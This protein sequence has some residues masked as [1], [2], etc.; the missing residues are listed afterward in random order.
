[1]KSKPEI[2][3]PKITVSLE[4][5]SGETK[6][7]TFS[8]PFR[9]GR[10]PDCELCIP[11]NCVS[12]THAEVVFEDGEWLLRDLNSANGVYVNGELAQTVPITDSVTVRLGN[13]GPKLAFSVE[14]PPVKTAGS[15]GTETTIAEYINRYFEPAKKDVNFGTHTMFVR[16]AF[17]KVQTK[18]KKKYWMIIAALAVLVS[19]VGAYAFYERHQ[20]QQQRKL[21]EDI[22]Y[23]M[24]SLDVDIAALE[25]MVMESQSQR[26]K[27]EILTFQARRKEMQKNY[28]KFLNS[29]NVYN[30]KLTEQD[31]L[32]LRIA[33][34]FGECE[35]NMPPGFVPEVHKYIDRWKSTDRL[36]N[37]VSVAVRNGYNVR[38][39]Q[40][41]LAQDLPPQFFYLALQESNFDPYIIGPETRKGIAKGMWQ[42][43]PETAIKYGLRVGPLADLRRPDPGDDR[44]R[45]DLA[46]KAAAH[47]LKDLYSTDAQASGLLVMA[48]YNWGENQVLP[49][50]RSMPANPKDRNFW[51]LLTKHRD[52]IPQE[53]YDYVFSIVSAAVIGEN[54]R[55]FGFSFDNPLGLLEQSASTQ[56]APIINEIVS[57]VAEQNRRFYSDSRAD[58]ALA[59]RDTAVTSEYGVAG[60]GQVLQIAKLQDT[61]RFVPGTALLPKGQNSVQPTIPQEQQCARFLAS[62]TIFTENCWSDLISSLEAN[63]A[64]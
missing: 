49:L 34:I 26:G 62:T 4:S 44:H 55:L 6:L 5:G 35:M 40:E 22:F 37:A 43:I 21:A 28:D 50:I 16:Q 10:L 61:R 56:K 54:P 48:S 32:I 36:A 60:R 41:M 8:Q 31:R 59:Q 25:L 11:E 20:A 45:V 46:T 12:R 58:G 14:K 7:F 33:R 51:E 1:M 63:I 47:Y 52:H 53:T 17:A 13:V 3:P 15:V 19:G 57:R 38:I 30:T 2:S 39:S 64:S 27:D 18:Q 29:L 42:F 23:N 24:K 9:I